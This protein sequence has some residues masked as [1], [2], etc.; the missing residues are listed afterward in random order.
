MTRS[1]G[2]L[3]KSGG[4]RSMRSTEASDMSESYCRA[5]DREWHC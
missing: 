5:A 2:W 4:M 1:V 3:W